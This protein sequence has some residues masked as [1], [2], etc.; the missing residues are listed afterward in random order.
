M[1]AVLNPQS[2]GDSLTIL[3]SAGPRLTK[4]WDSATGKPLAYEKVQQVSVQERF[5]CGIHALSALLAELEAERNTCIIRGK[6]IG[7]ARAKEL[8]PA[9]IE[10]EMRVK[11]K[12]LQTPKEGFTL[13]RLT[14]FKEQPLHFFY[15]DIDSFK[16]EGL[17]PVLQPEECINQYIEQ[18]LPACFQGITFHWQLSSGAGHPDNPGVL[19]AHVAFWLKTP[20]LGEDLEAWVKSEGLLI[21]VSVFRTVQPNYTAAPVFV[22]GVL[23]PVP[24]RSGLC[25]GFLGDEVDL[26]ISPAIVLR[27]RTER[28]ARAEMVDPRDKETVHGLFCRT[29]EIEEVVANW[30]SD[31]FE[32]VTEWRLTWMGGNGAGEGA[33][34]TENRQGIFNTHNTDPF[35]GRA[36]NKWDLVRHY[37]FG[38]LD[39]GVDAFEMLDIRDRPSEQAMREFVKTLP[40]MQ[41]TAVQEV[42]DSAATHRASLDAAVD[43]AGVRAVAQRISLDSAIDRV[44][45]ELLVGA[46]QARLRAIT[47][48]KPGVDSVR[49]MISLRGPR[50]QVHV[51]AP[52]WIKPWCY[53]AGEAKFFN[54]NTKELI[55]REAF[56]A[57]FCRMMDPDDDGNL[58]QASRIACDL[59]EIPVVY[60]RMYLP[61]AGELFTLDGKEYANDYR[62]E[63]EPIGVVEQAVNAVL[64]RHV[65]LLIPDR[66]YRELFLQWAAWVVRNPGKKV[67]WA[68]LVKGVEGDGKSVL[69][70]MIAQAMGHINVGIISPETMAGS[71]FNDWAKGRC[72]N[73]LEEIKIPGHRHDVYNKIKPLITNP[74]IEIHGKGKASTTVINT[75]NYIGFTNHDDAMPLD[76]KDRRNFVLF[77]PWRN[78]DE[79]HAAVAALGL[80]IDQYWDQLWDPIKNRPDAVRGF[81][82]S[83][84]ISAFNANSRAPATSFK[85]ELVAAGD[86]DDAEGHA[87]FWV[88]EGCFGVSKTVVSSACLTRKLGEMEPPIKIHT[89]RVRKVLTSMGFEQVGDV[90]KWKGASHR[91]WVQATVTSKVTS[92]STDWLRGELD[93]TDLGGAEDF[94]K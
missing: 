90:L 28:K 22:N 23:D 24:V 43:E 49:A 59:W 25:E 75:T 34:V 10:R 60:E 65:E 85:T 89:S 92:G 79:M 27:A 41:E 48:V 47:G 5:V 30:L 3:T 68:V 42:V 15:I 88:E 61:S 19:K 51:D 26:T 94:L 70:S 55:T 83:I 37:K 2:P 80:T 62:P 40:E 16:P 52:E 69:G 67:L 58:P 17:D 29:Y 86:L 31:Q 84:D 82:D 77:T 66:A 46:I 93:K 72:V 74:R 7:H 33:G 13:R 35:L 12:V 9:E 87:R 63:S 57:S 73:V 21:D 44:G 4:V 6:F 64:M 78:I 53:V 32:F 71:N 18:H 54:R 39:Q 50:V 45:R 81:F 36:A 11:K 8:Y 76:D 20:Q 56:D 14:F 1:S 91:V 38:H